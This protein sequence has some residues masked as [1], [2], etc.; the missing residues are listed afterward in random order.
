MFLA[1]HLNSQE[2]YKQKSVIQRLKWPQHVIDCLIT[3]DNPHGD[4]S[5]S[6]LELVSGLLSLEVLAQTFNICERTILSKTNNLN[7]LFWQ[8]KISITECP[9]MFLTLALVTSIYCGKI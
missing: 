8:H 4:I 7:E 1:P 9:T 6:D 2:C 5:N 3:S